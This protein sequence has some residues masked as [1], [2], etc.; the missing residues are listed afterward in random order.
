VNVILGFL[1]CGEEHKLRVFEGAGRHRMEDVT[2]AK[3]NV[4]FEEP[5]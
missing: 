2:G 1:T 5:S 4:I 3:E